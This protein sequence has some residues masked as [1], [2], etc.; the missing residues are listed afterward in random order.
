MSNAIDY[1]KYYIN[2][3]IRQAE[4]LIKN[5]KRINDMPEDKIEEYYIVGN[6]HCLKEAKQDEAD[7]KRSAVKQE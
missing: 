5:L 7:N 3:L 1:R 4:E 2:M 6:I